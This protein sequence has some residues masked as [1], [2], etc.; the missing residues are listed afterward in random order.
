MCASWR[1]RASDILQ[2][3]A[4]LE[5][6][7]SLHDLSAA[8]VAGVESNLEKKL[9]QALL[10]GEGEEDEAE[11]EAEAG[12]EEEDEE[13]EEE[14]QQQGGDAA[15]A[16]A[17]PEKLS[18]AALQELEE[19]SAALAAER[20]RLAQERKDSKTENVLLRVSSAMEMERRQ[21]LE[22]ATAAADSPM[23]V[24]ASIAFVNQQDKEEEK[25]EVR[26]KKLFLED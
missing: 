23:V 7:R 13:G 9:E 24:E 5:S 8:Q 12:T 10:A 15:P 25:I 3:A 20:A 6:E 26:P 17:I 21:S 19:R 1:K 22:E 16:P 18:E 2:H 11:A 4:T 14:Q